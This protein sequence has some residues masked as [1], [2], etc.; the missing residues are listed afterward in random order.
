MLTNLSDAINDLT[1]AT[2]QLNEATE[3]GKITYIDFRGYEVDALRNERVI[4]PA[5]LPDDF[6][7][8][9][10]VYPDEWEEL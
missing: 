8:C 1:E 10:D 6:E 3:F 7:E 9:R 5:P 2:R 4:G